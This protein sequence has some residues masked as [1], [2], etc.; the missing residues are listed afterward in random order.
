[1]GYYNFLVYLQLFVF[2]NIYPYASLWR[3]VKQ[4]AD[5]SAFSESM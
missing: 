4:E 1:M 2:F 5:C 3:V